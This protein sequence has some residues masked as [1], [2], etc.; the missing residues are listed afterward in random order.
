M[1]KKP[2]IK[3]IT[4]ISGFS[5][6]SVSK[7]LRNE[8]FVKQSTKDKILSAIRELGYQPDEIV[9]SLVLKKTINFI[10]LIVPDITNPFFF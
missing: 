5:K 9:R 3:D 1:G 6:L 8:H 10:G 7:V 2:T 4:K